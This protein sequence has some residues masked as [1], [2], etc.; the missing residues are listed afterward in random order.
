MVRDDRTVILCYLLK[1]SVGKASCLLRDPSLGN[2]RSYD[3]L[4]L[5]SWQRQVPRWLCAND[6]YER[7]V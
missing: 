2:G 5:K 4:S 6:T 3:S 7:G 1:L